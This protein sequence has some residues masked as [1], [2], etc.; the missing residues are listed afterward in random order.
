MARPREQA[1]L[2][3]ATK[4]ATSDTRETERSAQKLAGYTRE[5]YVFHADIRAAPGCHPA[6]G[7]RIQVNSEKARTKGGCFENGCCVCAGEQQGLPCPPVHVC[8][9]WGVSLG[10]S[11][12]HRKRLFIF[13]RRT[14]FLGA[15][16]NYTY[17]LFKSQSGSHSA[18]VGARMLALCIVCI[19]SQYH[20]LVFPP[21]DTMG[22]QPTCSCMVFAQK[23]ALSVGVDLLPTPGERAAVVP[24]R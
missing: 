18:R 3:S 6:Q 22:G 21:I 11:L 15:R 20:T 10:P 24:P 7:S 16:L 12:I 23:A 5:R 1:K 14:T 17:A 9:A 8:E 19:S 2:A 4:R 13:E